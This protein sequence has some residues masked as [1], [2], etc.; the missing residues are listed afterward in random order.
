MIVFAG[1]HFLF[2]GRNMIESAFW[3]PFFIV[4]LFAAAMASLAVFWWRARHHDLSR[5]YRSRYL[6]LVAELEAITITVNRMAGVLP[7]ISDPK[8]VDYYEG[9]LRILETLLGAAKKLP[10]SGSEP[11][12]LNSAFH[13]IRD[14]QARVK[15]T[16]KSFKRALRGRTVD[17]DELYGRSKPYLATGCYFCS[18]PIAMDQFSFI[19]V[20][21]EAKILKVL[22]CPVCHEELKQTKKIKI[23]N[24]LKDGKPAHWSEFP[25]YRPSQDFWRLNE[26]KYVNKTQ[27]LTLIQAAPDQNPTKAP[28]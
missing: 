4:G 28:E 1:S 7:K 19:Q 10:P 5:V 13:L 22:S 8:V 2:F 20:R 15:R 9:T 17:L 12:M 21:V 26:R 14:C 6:R 18:R 3:L 23:L 16:M 24:F 25:E 11:I 27:H